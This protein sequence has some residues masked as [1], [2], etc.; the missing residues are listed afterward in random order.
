MGNE[1]V[2]LF[3]EWADTYDQSV[4]GPDIE[5]KEVFYK[6]HSVLKEVA[7]RALGHVLEFGPGTGNLT[8]ELL[9]NNLTVTA[10][11]PSPGMRIK[12][13]EKLKNRALIVEGDFLNFQLDSTIQSIV[14]TYAFH[15]LTDDEKAAA[16]A[17]YSNMLPEGGK[18]IFADTMFESKEAYYQ[19]IRGAKEKGFHR[20]AEDLQSEYYTTLPVFKKLMNE[21]NFSV[22]FERVNNFVW[23]MEGAKKGNENT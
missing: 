22:T 23:I 14:S 20:L 2:E 19:T 13:M 16:L 10:V 3:D 1:F 12:A 8:L 4:A 17:I 7:K 9:K 15:H 11:E 21:N 6:Y 18:I 5:Y